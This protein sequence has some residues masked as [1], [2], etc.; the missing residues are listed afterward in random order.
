[1]TARW[2]ST[3]RPGCV[4]VLAFALRTVGRVRFELELVELEPGDVARARRLQDRAGAGRRTAGSAFGYVLFEDAAAGGV[5]PGGR[6]QRWGSTRGPSSVACSAARRSAASAPTRCSGPPRPGR[7]LVISGDTTPCEALRIAAHRGRRAR[8]RGDVRR[9]RAGARRRDRALDRRAG[10]DRSRA[11]PRSRLLAL[12]ARLDALSGRA[13]ARRGARDLPPTVLPRDFDTIEIPFARARRAGSSSAW[14]ERRPRARDGRRRSAEEPARRAV[15]R[16]P[17][18]S[19]LT[20]PADVVALRAEQSRERDELEAAAAR[21][22]G[23]HAT[24]H[25]GSRDR[26]AAP[27]VRATAGG[28]SGALGALRLRPLVLRDRANVGLGRSGRPPAHGRG[29]AARRSRSSRALMAAH[30]GRVRRRP[31]SR[32]A[33]PTYR[34]EPL[35]AAAGAHASAG[36]TSPTAGDGAVGIACDRDIVHADPPHALSHGPPRA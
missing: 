2:R 4:T 21:R 20:R 9:G 23:V 34:A 17:P 6:A 13:A 22:H 3:G 28:D 31:R 18:P 10:G 26:A 27:M 30:R 24:R 5:R 1:M 29:S 12:N 11:M 36:S 33:G 35:A 7:K 14:S 19:A 32:Y 25:V 15:S 16:S 8:A